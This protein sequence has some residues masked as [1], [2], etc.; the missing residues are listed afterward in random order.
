MAS[1]LNGLS[2]AETVSLVKAMTYS[3]K[4]Q[5][6]VDLIAGILWLILKM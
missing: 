1:Y 4:S 5:W 3:G 2:Q 6:D